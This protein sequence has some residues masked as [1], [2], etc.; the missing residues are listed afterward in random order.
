MQTENSPET[1]GLKRFSLSGNQLKILAM[2]TMLID[3]I[4]VWFFPQVLALRLIGRLS[5]P[6]FAYMI[7]EGCFYTKHRGM[8]LMKIGGLALACQIVF[9]VFMKSWQQGIL[10]T[11]TLSILSI[12]CIDCF[13]KMKNPLVRVGCILG[14]CGIVFVSLIAPILF[15]EQGFTIDYRFFGVLTPVAVYYA[16]G[17]WIKILCMA[18]MLVG[19][20]IDFGGRQWCA[21]AA[22]PFLAAYS[23][24]RG[25]RNLKYMFYVFYPTHLVLIYLISLLLEKFS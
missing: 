11:F 23:G 6:I 9:L 15:K 1:S 19:V 24:K 14:L 22:L 21:L 12:Y 8:Y 4:G 2:I 20:A 18:V 25:T 16:K 10:I 17:K 3:H 13:I 5:F 7:A